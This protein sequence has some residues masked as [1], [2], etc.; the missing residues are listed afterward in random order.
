MDLPPPA[1]SVQEPL[2]LKKGVKPAMTVATV[3]VPDKIL[4]TVRA[5][6]LRSCAYGCI[7]RVF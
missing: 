4:R 7:F 1:L 3:N 2:F 6:L 5:S